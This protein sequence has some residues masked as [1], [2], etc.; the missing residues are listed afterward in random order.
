MGESSKS[1]FSGKS[2]CS[3]VI[4]SSLMNLCL[5]QQ[6]SCMI[7]EE[8]EHYIGSDGKVMNIIQCTD[9]FFDPL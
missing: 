4:F 2:S 5:N 6:V 3:V 1:V 7:Y 9:L 8:E